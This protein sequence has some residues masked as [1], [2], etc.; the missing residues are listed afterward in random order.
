M[1]L[2][3]NLKED[4]QMLINTNNIS[5]ISVI[6][7]DDA[8]YYHY[9]SP[10]SMGFWKFIIETCWWFKNRTVGVVSLGNFIYWDVDTFLKEHK[11]FQK[12]YNKICERPKVKICLNDGTEI[13]V[14]FRILSDAEDFAKEIPKHMWFSKLYPYTSIDTKIYKR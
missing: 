4:K 14:Y 6:E 1:P 3:N 12:V 10:K 13:S 8:P 11:I 7:N 9:Y 5:S 2:V